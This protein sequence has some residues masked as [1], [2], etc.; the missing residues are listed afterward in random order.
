MTATV[1]RASEN[2]KLKTDKI[3]LSQW[4]CAP[5]GSGYFARNSA[6]RSCNISCPTAMGVSFGANGRLHGS[7]LTI[8]YNDPCQRSRAY[9]L[10]CAL[11]PG[12]C[13]TSSPQL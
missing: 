12:P 1:P 7:T 2:L 6:T 4:L 5:L 3:A 9:V 11:A 13:T 8:A 10:D